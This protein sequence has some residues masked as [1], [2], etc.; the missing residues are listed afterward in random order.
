VKKL[1]SLVPRVVLV[2]DADAGGDTGVDRALEVFVRQDM[3]LSVATLPA[4]LDPCDL[5]VQ[6]GP[7]P[8]VRA[9]ESAVD[10]FEFKLQQVWEQAQGGVDDQYRALERI[11]GVLALSPDLR[12][13][14]L[15]LMVN[16]I[17]HR[18]SLKEENVWKRLRE[19]HAKRQSAG[20][21]AT[22]AAGPLSLPSP[23]SGEGGV[24]GGRGSKPEEPTPSIPAPRH[25][26]ELVEI[27]LAEPA[28]VAEAQSVIA[29]SQIEHPQVRQ[30]VEGLYR[31]AA[32]GLPPDL[33][34][35]RGRL[36]NESLLHKAFQRQQRG[37]DMPDRRGRLTSVL[38]R[39]RERENARR[40]KELH[41][42]LQS[43]SGHEAARD[44]LRKLQSDPESN[45]TTPDL[46]HPSP[47]DGQRIDEE[48]HR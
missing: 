4:G 25:E 36:D 1:R 41:D 12:S 30:L 40:I 23:H 45:G 35:L 21:E 31:L 16:R 15:Q 10:V 8:F 27:L 20:P 26:V 37:L 5:L 43:A 9:L 46:P 19:L 28:L 34:H 32:E 39:F 18:F 11:L 42:K 17:A 13:S 7:E 33:D 38:A 44:L 3:K 22:Q 48:D 6:Q 2:F 14:K 29:S 24:R 47:Q